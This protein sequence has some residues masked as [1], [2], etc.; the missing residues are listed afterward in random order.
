MNSGDGSSSRWVIG[1]IMARASACKDKH[2]HYSDTF[3][4]GLILF[5]SIFQLCR[6][7][8]SWVEP[9]LRKVILI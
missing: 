8:P 9:V 3:L 4:F 2:L 7:R 5:F 6:D 1:F